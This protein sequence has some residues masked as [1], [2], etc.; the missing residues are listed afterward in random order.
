[1]DPAIEER[2]RARAYAIWEEEGRPPGRDVEHWIRAVLELAR[3]GKIRMLPDGVL[4][5]DRVQQDDGVSNGDTGPPHAH[6]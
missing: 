6:P 4:Q 5:T 1:M 3:D 2:I